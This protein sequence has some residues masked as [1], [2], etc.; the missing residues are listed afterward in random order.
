MR[1]FVPFATY[2]ASNP[3]GQNDPTFY[4]L[5]HHHIGSDFAVPIG[6][7]IVTPCEGE[8]AK[9]VFNAARGNTAIFLFTIDGQDWGVEFC[10]LR[11]LPSLGT[12]KEGDVIAFSGNT[13]T[14]CTGPHVHVTLHKGG[15]VTKDYELLTSESAYISLWRTGQLV[16]PYLWFWRAINTLNQ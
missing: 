8:V 15:Y 5:T 4:P 16:D 13:G 2:V 11:E 10:H 6:T 14:A 1:E 7:Q 12:F 9:V 3:F